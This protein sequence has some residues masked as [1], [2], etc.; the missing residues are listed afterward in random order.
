MRFLPNQNKISLKVLSKYSSI[1][2]ITVFIGVLLL[3]YLALSPFYNM[4]LKQ[5][6]EIKAKTKSVNER[7]TNLVELTKI[8]EDFP[9]FPDKTDRLEKMI[10]DKDKDPGQFFAQIEKIAKDSG[11]RLSSLSPDSTS[12]QLVAQIQLAGRYE[13]FKNFL[14]SLE[15][16]LLVTEV[17][18]LSIS[19]QS[20][21]IT[22]NL[23]IKA[24]S[25]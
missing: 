17:I 7:K 10:V 5:E 12:G 14:S 1:L 11:V 24:G 9:D 19:G 4:A 3:G 22:F 23:K 21:N 18:S 13:D 6:R 20:D 2:N 15:D 8:K 16:N 25:K